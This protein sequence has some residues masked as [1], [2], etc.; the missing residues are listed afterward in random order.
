MYMLKYLGLFFENRSETLKKGKWGLLL[1]LCCTPALHVILKQYNCTMEHIIN[2]LYHILMYSKK[3]KT[4]HS[5][6]QYRLNKIKDKLIKCFPHNFAWKLHYH[7]IIKRLD[8]LN[9]SRKAIKCRHVT[10]KC[11]YERYVVFIFNLLFLCLHTY[12]YMQIVGTYFFF[13]SVQSASQYL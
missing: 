1:I 13:T 9:K 5:T 7:K 6:P 3:Q 10:Y 11:F 4:P 8:N 12:I 2:L